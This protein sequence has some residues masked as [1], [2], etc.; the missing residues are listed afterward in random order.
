ME[1]DSHFEIYD[2]L[3]D[4]VKMQEKKSSM[5]QEFLSDQKPQEKSN[6]KS[7]LPESRTVYYNWNNE[8]P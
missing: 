5:E 6:K 1:K 3:D 2:N 4:I 8:A 7:K